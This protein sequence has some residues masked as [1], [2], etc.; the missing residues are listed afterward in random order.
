MSE[1]RDRNPLRT[2]VLIGLCCLLVYNSNRRAISAGDT[3]P[4]RYLPFAILQDHTLRM[5]PVAT[6]AAQGR[7]DGAY[8]MLP[9]RDGRLISLYPITLPVLITPLYVPAIAY[10]HQQGW[11]GARLDFVA[12]IMEKLAASLLAALSVALFYPVLLRRTTARIALL[13]CFAYAFGTTTWVISSQALWQHGLAQLLLIAALLFLTAPYS[14]PRALAAGFLCGLVACNRPPDV[15]LA[16]ALGVYALFW[17]GWRGATA[18]V[19]SAAVPVALVVLYNLRATGNLGGGYGVIASAAFF[20]HDLLTGTGGLLLSPTRGL[21]VFSPFL[22][23]LVL[24][25]RYLSQSRG[26]R[27]LTVLMGLSVAAQIAL[28]AKTDWRSGLSWGPRYMTDLVPF[29]I[30]MLGPVVTALRRIARACFLVAVAAAAVIEGIGAF[31]YCDWLDMPIYAAD[32][33]PHHDMGPA[34]RWRNAPFVTSLGNGLAP[35]ELW[36]EPRGRFEALESGGRPTSSVI[37]GEE[38]FATGWALAGRATPARV[39]VIVDGHQGSV[40]AQFSDRPDVRAALHEAN[41][42]GWRLRLDTSRLAAGEHHL[43]AL[44]WTAEKGEARYLD[45]RTLIVRNVDRVSRQS[46]GAEA[47]LIGVWRLVEVDGVPDQG[48][49]ELDIRPDGSIVYAV[50]ATNRWQ[51]LNLTYRIEG[52]TIVSHQPSEAREER[53]T[54]SIAEDG[55]LV[56]EVGGT[57]R[58]FRRSEKE[59]GLPDVRDGEIII[60]TSQSSQSKAVQ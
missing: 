1:P 21:L 56:I 59:S 9:T 8:W 6:V 25:P 22:F 27:L 38:V 37:A 13:L 19:A 50:K 3:Y 24:A 23:F 17:A 49:T 48:H 16:A 7:G 57:R 53:T 29:L 31:S 4:A 12:R 46:T 15:I 10:L 33:D 54:Y 2:S 47:A 35:A 28:Y 30:W 36:I 14:A 52:N 44:L 39:A 55:A 45:E 20:Q 26:E 51:V 60:H 34:W 40:S 41:R 43:T 18:L 32:H 58:V 11:T 5:N 42:C